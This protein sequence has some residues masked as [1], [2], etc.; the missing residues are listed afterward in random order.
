[1]IYGRSARA[2]A[3]LPYRLSIAGQASAAACRRG[4]G[5]GFVRMR[6]APTAIV[7][8]PLVARS[9]SRL[10]ARFAIVT[11]CCQVRR[12]LSARIRNRSTSVSW[13]HSGDAR[14]LSSIGSQNFLNIDE[15]PSPREHGERSETVKEN[16]LN[17]GDQINS[18]IGDARDELD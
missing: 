13:P 1:M 6:S 7:S 18:E 4:N 3:A 12:R 17:G 16:D 10:S 11:A 15:H 8:R 14:M 5:D 9:R 2:G